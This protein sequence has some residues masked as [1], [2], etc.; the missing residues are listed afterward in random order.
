MPSGAKKR[1]A[2]KR[3]KQL[4]FTVAGAV[5]S[6]SSDANN[7]PSKDGGDTSDEGEGATSPAS[8]Q[9]SP[10]DPVSKLMEPPPPSAEE[11]IN[12][13]DGGAVAVDP[14]VVAGSEK[15]PVES[16]SSSEDS[17]A[18]LD[19][20]EVHVVVAEEAA[21][22]VA[23]VVVEEVAASSEEVVIEMEVKIVPL[24]EADTSET[25]AVE[26]Q[27][28]PGIVETVEREVISVPPP[29]VHR[30]SWGSCCGLFDV[31][32]GSTR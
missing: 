30:T 15:G 11:V 4:G 10:R 13:G 28:E 25:V 17:E 18:R 22:E 12:A 21:V 32:M 5:G 24:S 29:V 6:S 23:P 1:K 7:N 20:E 16:S 9:L 8:P 31:L 2:A 19:S 14:E 3:K 27:D 26:N